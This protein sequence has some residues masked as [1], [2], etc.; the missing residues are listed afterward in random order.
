MLAHD[1]IK[2]FNVYI[3]KHNYVEMH[4]G[5]LVSIHNGLTNL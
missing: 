4:F 2:E 1:S 3:G 5:I